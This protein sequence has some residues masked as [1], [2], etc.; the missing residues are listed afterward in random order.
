M[1]CSEQKKIYVTYRELCALMVY[2]IGFLSTLVLCNAVNRNLTIGLKSLPYLGMLD[3]VASACGFSQSFLFRGQQ[4]EAGVFSIKAPA[5][6]A[7]I[8]ACNPRHFG[9]NAT[10]ANGYSTSSVHAVDT[11]ETLSLMEL[12]VQQGSH[13]TGDIVVLCA[14]SAR[15]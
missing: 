4:F 1:L 13:G 11:N 10:F 5:D 9:Q 3:V 2:C 12:K 8:F 14:S 7:R 6:F 15:W